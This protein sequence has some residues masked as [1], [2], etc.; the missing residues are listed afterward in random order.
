MFNK[1]EKAL[2]ALAT[3]LT[4]AAPASAQAQDIKGHQALYQTLLSHGVSVHINPAACWES[5][6]M[7]WYQGQARKIVVCQSNKERPGVEVNQW[8]DEDLDTL[9]HE[10]HHF[11]QD[12]L[13]G[14][15]HDHNLSPIYTRPISL[16][17]DVLGQAG[18][19]SIAEQYRMRGASDH[20]VILE[21][22]AF[23]VA[24]MNDP[25]EQ[26]KDIKNYC[27]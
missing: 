19:E 24:A 10:A 25:W 8:L 21:L 9:R 18:I 26:V 3:A 1:L 4:I 5:G 22:E 17:K 16:A 14:R 13:D 12:C 20:V 15:N 6:A 11:A 2:V 23:S 27:G 7:G